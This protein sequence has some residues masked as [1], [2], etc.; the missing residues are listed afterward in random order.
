LVVGNWFLEEE[1]DSLKEWIY[2]QKILQR[3][4]FPTCFPKGPPDSE[5]LTQKQQSPNVKTKLS[6]LIV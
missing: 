3:F 1:A 2:Q 6:D 4:S 5:L